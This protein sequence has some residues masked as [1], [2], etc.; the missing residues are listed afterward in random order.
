MKPLLIAILL[1]QNLA[2]ASASSICIKLV[3]VI[4]TQT[5][6]G[7]N[8]TRLADL[9]LNSDIALPKNVEAYIRAHPVYKRFEA[10]R[11]S[12]V[13]IKVEAFLHENEILDLKDPKIPNLGESVQGHFLQKIAD[14]ITGHDPQHAPETEIPLRVS[15]LD[16]FENDATTKLPAAKIEIESDFDMTDLK[17]ANPSFGPGYR[18]LLRLSLGIPR[19]KEVLSFYVHR[20]GYRLIKKTTDGLGH[21]PDVIFLT[22]SGVESSP[23]FYKTAAEHYA[24]AENGGY[25]VLKLSMVGPLSFKT[26]PK[27]LVVNDMRGKTPY[28]HAIANL[29]AVD[30]PINFFE[31]ISVGTPTFWSNGHGPTFYNIDRLK[32]MQNNAR[33]SGIFATADDGESMSDFYKRSSATVL[34]SAPYV[35]EAN[36]KRSIDKVLEK[37]GELMGSRIKP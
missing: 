26:F 5:N 15:I 12:G 31:P 13:R 32:Q 18:D 4:S 23:L 20:D 30:G 29:A 11:D 36:G 24:K 8:A 16:N 9:G 25:K 7:K 1:W 2:H 3:E 19:D 37:L 27:L 33:K 17:Q 22:F 28:L 21:T 35:E 14:V 10:L 6:Q 34:S